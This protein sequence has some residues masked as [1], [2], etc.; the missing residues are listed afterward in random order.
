MRRDRA[1]RIALVGSGGGHLLQLLALEDWWR[2]HDRLWVAPDTPDVRASLDGERLVPAFHPTTRN[3]PNLL[4]NTWLAVRVLRR[5]R[6]TVIIS[7]GAGVAVP[8]FW[9]ARWFGARTIYL[10]VFDRIDSSTMTGR[11]CYPVTDAFLVQ[12]ERQRDAYPAAQVV[13]PVL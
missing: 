8:F 3:V 5:E 12:W 2:A 9:L 10:E 13:G 11:L 1:T 6:P 4:R 7:T